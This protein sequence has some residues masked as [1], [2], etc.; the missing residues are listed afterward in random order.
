MV[1]LLLE[2]QTGEVDPKKDQ[3]RIKREATMVVQ[4]VDLNFQLIHLK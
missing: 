3:I 1:T 4:T 2:E